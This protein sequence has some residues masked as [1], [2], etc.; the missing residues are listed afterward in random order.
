MI[1]ESHPV[2]FSF[3]SKARLH[4]KIRRRSQRIYCGAECMAA[5]LCHA[6]PCRAGMLC[7][8][9]LCIH[10]VKV[11]HSAMPWKINAELKPYEPSQLPWTTMGL[12]PGHD[13]PAE[14][15]TWPHISGSPCHAHALLS[16]PRQ[17]CQSMHV[18]Y[19]AHVYSKLQRS[20][21]ILVAVE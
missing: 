8:V 17:I 13:L 3:F 11:I 7:H 18:T 19:V 5:T 21:H 2:A 15:F 4:L 20:G 12:Y 16:C 14:G 9:V 1:N 6:M 10:G